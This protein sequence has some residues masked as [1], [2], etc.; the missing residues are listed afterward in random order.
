MKGGQGVIIPWVILRQG[1]GVESLS[2]WSILPLRVTGGAAS[3]L[4]AEKCST[5]REHPCYS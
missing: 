3:W 4:P 5:R 2:P 1:D